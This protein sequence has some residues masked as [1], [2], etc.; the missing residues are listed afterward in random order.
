[1]QIITD[2]LR[3]LVVLLLG[4]SVTPAAQNDNHFAV[5][6]FYCHCSTKSYKINLIVVS[7][8]LTL[9]SRR[10]CSESGRHFPMSPQKLNRFGQNVADGWR[11]R[12]E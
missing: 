6:V 7:E 12:K 1:L 10:Y 4:F 5:Y 11:M 9:A 8:K 2:V 3:F